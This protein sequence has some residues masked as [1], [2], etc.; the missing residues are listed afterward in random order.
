MPHTSAEFEKVVREGGL[1]PINRQHLGGQIYLYL[2]EGRMDANEEMDVPHYCMI[3]AAG[4]DDNLQVGQY[5]RVA[6]HYT[7]PHSQITLPT[8]R[9]ERVKL[10]EAQARQQIDL[11]DSVELWNAQ[12]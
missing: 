8:T 3:W 7:L 9:D 10:C 5:V 6:T 2:A 1:Q 12:G 4:F 11:A